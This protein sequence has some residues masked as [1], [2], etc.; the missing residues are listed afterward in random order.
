MNVENLTRVLSCF[1]F[2][3]LDQAASTSR[4]GGRLPGK[5]L[6]AYTDDGQ[7]KCK[8]IGARDTNAKRIMGGQH[9][10]LKLQEIWLRF[11]RRAMGKLNGYRNRVAA[12]GLSLSER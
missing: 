6:A 4:G 7:S 8:A 10:P 1:A 11:P 5:I 12:R 2:S 9:R 3:A